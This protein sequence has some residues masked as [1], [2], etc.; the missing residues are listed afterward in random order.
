MSMSRCD[1]KRLAPAEVP[2][3]FVEIEAIIAGESA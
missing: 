3:V 2:P 1:C